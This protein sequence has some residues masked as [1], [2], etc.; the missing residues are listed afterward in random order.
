[1]NPEVK[2]LFVDE[3]QPGKLNLVGLLKAS[4]MTGNKI[5]E[6]GVDCITFF[7]KKKLK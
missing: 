4:L 6:I 5:C 2:R 3:S 1:M 7:L